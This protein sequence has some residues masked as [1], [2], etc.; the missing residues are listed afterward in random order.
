LLPLPEKDAE[1]KWIVS[2][3]VCFPMPHSETL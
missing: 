2:K 1:D 3:K